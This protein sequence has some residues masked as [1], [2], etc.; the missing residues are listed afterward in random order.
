MVEVELPPD[1]T[2]VG[3]KVAVPPAGSPLALKVTVCAAP[4]TTVVLMVL[5]APCPWITLSVVGLALIEKSSVGGGEKKLKV[6]TSKVAPFSPV[7][8]R[9]T[10]APLP[11]TRR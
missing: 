3:L 8:V 1:V 7:G 4:L 2:A 9:V 10:D 11:V 5:V 6:G